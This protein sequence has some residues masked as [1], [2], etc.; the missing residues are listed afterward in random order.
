V[1]RAAVRRLGSLGTIAAVMLASCAVGGARGSS[2]PS[3]APAPAGGVLAARVSTAAAPIYPLRVSPNGRYLVDQ[4][5]VPFL[6][7]GDSPQAM[8]GD[9]S[10]TDAELFLANRRATG[11]NTVWINLLCNNYTGCGADGRTV[12]GIAPFSTAG[13]LGTP[14]EA[15]FAHADRVIRLAATYGIAVLLDPIE[16][17]GWLPMLRAN[18]PVK[19]QAF[20]RYLGRR[21]GAFPNVVWMSGNDFQSWAAAGDDALVLAVAQGIKDADPT[22]LQTIELNYFVS[23]SLDDQRWAPLIGLDAAYT[24]APTY[25]EV[26]KEYNR[27][28]VPTFMVEANYELEH[29]YTGPLTLRRQEYW[30]MLSGA[31]GQLYG[32]RDTWQF[33]PGWKGRLDTQGSIELG[34]LSSL[35]A[36]RAWYALVPDQLHQV[37]TAGGGTFTASG[38]VNASDYVTAARTPD[39]ALVI[40]YMPSARPISVDLTQLTGPVIARWYD[41][42]RG[43]YV[44]IAGSPFANSGIHQFVPPGLNGGG[45]DDWVLVLEAP[46]PTPTPSPSATGTPGQ[47]SGSVG[48]GIAPPASVP[49]GVE[50]LHAAWYG[51]SGYPSL[52]PG[53]RATATV[54]YYNAG[55][56]GWVASR[57]GEVAYL[58]TWNPVPGQD[59][60]SALGGDGHAGSPST[61]WPRFNRLAIQ[62]ADY[63]GPGQV[64]WFQFTVQAPPVP[65]HYM[66]AIRPLIE[67][68]QWMEDYG[69]FWY[70]T[71]LNVD[72]SPPR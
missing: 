4:N 20:G 34:Y 15:Y 43:T 49:G 40:A 19:S 45:A 23:A 30:A 55:T 52:C 33:L 1:L 3:S 47:C 44:G 42:T 59:Q 46:T 14:N 58:G 21:Y 36:G 41:P 67:G 12:D 54:A 66:L 29:D 22:H 28:G 64:A 9:L 38:S 2:V 7:V 50:G 71:V 48:P 31:A 51:Q 72:G 57:L 5:G 62:P 37:V 10:E 35:L 70:V 69:V 61:G 53:G 60:P 56:T 24:Y 25:A 13:D 11:F 16:T 39:G 26:L 63:V 32:N 65:G 6:I 68:A 8:I 27:A 17:G 18:G